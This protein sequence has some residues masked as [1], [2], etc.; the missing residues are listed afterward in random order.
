MHYFPRAAIFGGF[1]HAMIMLAESMVQIGRVANV[2]AS[3]GLTFQYVH[4]EH[5][6]GAPGP[7]IGG[8]LPAFWFPP[9][10][11]SIQLSY[12]VVRPERFELPAFWFV[13]R[14]SIQLSYGRTWVV[15]IYGN[16]IKRKRL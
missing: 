10:A 2:E 13:A 5:R 12:R 9:S 16:A 11:D 6:N 8:E 14:R 15:E 4:V 3:G 1:R 7:A